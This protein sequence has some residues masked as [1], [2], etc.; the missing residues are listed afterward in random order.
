MSGYKEST[1]STR[2]R[3][4]LVASRLVGGALLVAT[5][6]PATVR[7]QGSDGMP[8]ES[9]VDQSSYLG[10]TPLRV[11]HR[12]RGFGEETAE[13]A[14]GTH[15]AMPL[16]S[17][18][19]FMDGQ[20][21]VGNS[22]Q[23]FS[24]NFGGGVRLRQDDYFTGSPRIFGFSF[25]YDGEDTQLDN[26]FNQLGVSFERLGPLVDLRLNANIPLEDVKAGDD[27]Q[28]SGE[29]TFQGNNL[30]QTTIADADAALRV[31]DFEIAPRLFNLNAWFYAGGYQMDGQ[32]VSEFGEKGGVRGYIMNDLALDVGVH[33]DDLFGTTTVVQIIWTPGR[34]SADPSYW[35]HTIDDRMRE[36]VYRNTYVAVSRTQVVGSEIVTDEDGDPFNIVHVDSTAAEGGDG[37]FENP[38]NDLDEITNNTA[39]ADI[40]LAHGGSVFSNQSVT[41]KDAQRFLG[42]GNNVTHTVVSQQLGEITLPETAPGALT[43]PKPI[44]EDSTGTAAVILAGGNMEVEDLA[45]IE[46]SN[47]TIDGGTRGVFSPNG[48]ADV[49]INNM[50]I[51]NT[52]Q[53]GIELTELLET[54]EAGT[55]RLRFTPT[56]DD[57]MFTSVGGDDI[58]LNATNAEPATVPITETIVISDITSTNGGEVG[59]RLT[60]H[61][62]AATITDFMW[63]G[64]TTGDGALLIDNTVTQGT[65]T[66]NGVNRLEAG[67]VGSAF[68]IRLEGG[69]ATHTVTGTTIDDMGGDAIVAVGP[70]TAGLNFTGRITQETNNASIL[71]VSGGH[72]GNMTFTELTAGQGVVFAT[73]GDGIQFDDADG[74][75]TFNDRVEIDG[76][77]Q[78]VN[79]VNSTAVL[80]LTDALF[81]DTTGTTIAFDGGT[82]NMTLTGRVEQLTNA[83]TLLSVT[84]G[85]DGTLAFNEL[86]AGAGVISADI[87][88][89]LQ[90]DN[91]D[92]AY[93]FN[94]EVALN[95]AISQAVNIDGTA[96][97]SEGT[98][99]F[100][101]VNIAFADA[102]NS[103]VRIAN[104]APQTFSMA[105]EITSTAGR[106]VE[107]FN[108]SGGSIVFSAAITANMASNGILINGNEG[109]ANSFTGAV[110]LTTGINAGV[111]ISDNSGGSTS[112]NNLDITTTS[113][114]GFAVTNSAGHAVSVTGTD[115]TID[116][117][118]GVALRMDTANVGT[119]GVNFRTVNVDGGAGSSNAIS[120][121]TVTGSAIAIGA[122]TTNAGDG[123]V[124]QNTLQSAVVLND[125]ASFSMNRVNIT[126]TQAGDAISV[127]DAT[128]LTLNNLNIT[129]VDA[130]DGISIEDSA[131]A[132]LS[133]IAI[134]DTV[135]GNALAIVE[136]TTSTVTNLDVED[137][138]GGNGVVVTDVTNISMANLDINDTEVGFDGI[139]INH[140]NTAAGTSTVSV[141][142]SEI[143]NVGGQ[144]IDY[145]R[146]ATNT[147]R[148]TL[149]NNTI[150]VG[151][152]GAEGIAIDIS[153]SS[154]ANITIN[155]TNDVDAGPNQEALFVTT[156]GGALKTVRIL[157]NDNSFDNNDATAPAADFQIGGAVVFNANITD[158]SFTNASGTTGR[159]FEMESTSGGATVR[160]NLNGND[161]DS[162]D[163]NDFLLT[164]TLGDFE[165]V[166]LTDLNTNNTGG[167]QT[168]GTFD[169]IAGPVPTPQ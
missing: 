17:G 75:Y 76:A 98:F 167:V 157:V 101:D 15:W 50:M 57:V 87:G 19:A 74:V 67:T 139:Q 169:D 147:S 105:G 21:R 11:W 88:N 53:D 8:F 112:F 54:L 123:G 36:H 164:E 162:P 39:I 44:I 12:T 126:N 14:F 61:K 132:N 24:G 28:V 120:L 143:T 146:A 128:S 150:N 129:E 134:T 85:H 82:A 102:A 30:A 111:T 153:G 58:D 3:T 59:I 159:A 106:P 81:T 124:I 138:N 43:G 145:I 20:F 31:V 89:G 41:L 46:V 56:I 10:Q 118:I 168:V 62:R 96:D 79:V 97:E 107:L 22:D 66:M 156:S 37:T 4:A 121:D 60:E 68:A 95:G 130:G 83:Q 9:V 6:V 2:F 100:A 141:T 91:A 40:I 99:S 109:G 119:G 93:N 7:A 122:G 27:V 94:H 115:N 165:V 52:T 161:G 42:E 154:D 142:N 155:G 104:S 114:D 108:N 51:M 35:A 1:V 70:G 135:G 26:W 86:T 25:W 158:N 18:L 33:D 32:D 148:L 29:A 34:V 131:T 48:V 117:T 55:T 23:D 71:S 45:E 149:T 72:D 92:G 63:N 38:F 5:L 133:N 103:A 113:G 110:S 151:A 125:V 78:A 127:I 160:L 116:T 80:T 13:T 49:N 90:F 16:T 163:A 166:D 65:V 77:V 84:N 152:T 69:A 144:G 47:F 137:V 140:T 136:T 64:G 73:M